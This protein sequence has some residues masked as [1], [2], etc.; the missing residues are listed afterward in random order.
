MSLLR[1]LFIGVKRTSQIFAPKSEKDPE[2]DIEIDH[3]LSPRVCDPSLVV[4]LLVPRSLLGPD[5]KRKITS[6]IQP[7]LPPID[8]GR[9]I[10]TTEVRSY[11]GYPS[12]DRLRR[13]GEYSC[14]WRLD[15]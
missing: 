5:I 14:R 11:S 12:G 7:I 4:L 8:I 6:G 10:S 3:H 2:P 13:G 9:G 1:H 15:C